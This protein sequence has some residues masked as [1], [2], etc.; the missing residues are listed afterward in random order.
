MITRRN[1]VKAIFPLAELLELFIKIIDCVEYLHRE[2]ISH[3]D[4]KPENIFMTQEGEGVKIANLG[5]STT[6]GPF[7]GTQI[8]CY[9]PPE[10]LSDELIDQD[11]DV[12]ALGAIL[13][14]LVTMVKAYSAMTPFE[15]GKKIQG[16]EYDQ[17]LLETNN[18]PKEIIALIQGMM[19]VERKNRYT[20]QEVKSN[21]I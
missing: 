15:L 16:G 21:I 14:E 3:K 12:W 17:Q 4:L 19:M 10:L 8:N 2:K 1:K 18:C 6:L 5:L 13:Y 11:S 20:L 7:N 9:S